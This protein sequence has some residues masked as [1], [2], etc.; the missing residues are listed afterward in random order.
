MRHVTMA[1]AAAVLALPTAARAQSGGTDPCT[2]P[3]SGASCDFTARA[4]RAAYAQTG[5]LAAGGNPVPGVESTRGITLG[6]IP[7]T[8]A[9]LRVSVARQLLP[10]LNEGP[11]ANEERTATATAIRLG[12]ATRL[13]EGVSAGPVSG[14]GA[15]DLLLD[16]AYLPPAGQ[17]N[18]GAAAFGAGA[19]IGIIRETFGTPGVALSVMYRHV[20]TQQYGSLC[21]VPDVMCDDPGYGEAEFAV[22]DI[23]GRLTV[24]KRLGPIGVLGGVG[25]DRFSTSGGEIRFF[26]AVLEPGRAELPIRRHDRRFSFFANLSYALVVGSLVAEGGWME[27][28]EPELTFDGDNGSYQAGKG[29][30]F[31]SL[32]LRISL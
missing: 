19:R 6:I 26:P 20:G 8:T 29:T 25:V 18:E 28:G 27:G 16:A 21:S 31:G 2:E 23:S 12:T 15:I 22:N 13:F 3:T 32:A 11:V 24:G 30:P 14:V 10:D 5:I 1:L 9:S 7:K 4:L 17:S